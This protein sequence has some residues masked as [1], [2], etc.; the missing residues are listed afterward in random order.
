MSTRVVYSAYGK[1]YD[2]EACISLS[3]ALILARGIL[4]I[5]GRVWLVLETG[6][7]TRY[8]FFYAQLDDR[9]DLFAYL[10]EGTSFV[11]KLGS[12]AFTVPSYLKSHIA[13]GQEVNPYTAAVAC[14]LANWLRNPECSHQFYDWKQRVPKLESFA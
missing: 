4:A 10:G 7:G 1:K 6:D 12:G 13:Y 11:L 9:V 8:E 14:D 5:E 2:P 3:D